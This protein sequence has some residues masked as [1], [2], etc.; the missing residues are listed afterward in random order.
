MQ[1][2]WRRATFTSCAPATAVPRTQDKLII[3]VRQMTKELDP[4]WQVTSSRLQRSPGHPELLRGVGGSW[5]RAPQEGNRE[6]AGPGHSAGQQRA[7]GEVS[8]DLTQGP[9]G[10][11][12][13]RGY[14]LWT[15]A[16]QLG[17]GGGR[18]D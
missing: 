6:E 7:G 13:P 9:L 5:L 18:G 4:S 15:D 16:V 11:S 14:Q 10:P 3:T 8:P 17:G 1:Q 12:A 2:G